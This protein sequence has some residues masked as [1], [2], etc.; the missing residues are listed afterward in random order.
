MPGLNTHPHQKL[1]FLN[2]NFSKKR[3]RELKKR[4]EPVQLKRIAGFLQVACYFGKILPDIMRQHKLIVQFRSPAREGV[5]VRLLPKP[6]Q[7]ASNQKQLND[8]H[9]FVGGHVKTSEF[10]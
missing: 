8:T 3:K 1:H 10:Q 4:S 2:H 6:G 5:V 7:E 9:L